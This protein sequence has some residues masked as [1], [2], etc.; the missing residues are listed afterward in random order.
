MGYTVSNSGCLKYIITATFFP[1]YIFF[2]FSCLRNKMPRIFARLIFGMFL[3]LIGVLSILI[4]DVTSHAQYEHKDNKSLCLFDIEVG[5]NYSVQPSTL[6]MHWA[7]LI[8]ANIFLG[9]G[10]YLVT[11]TTFE[12]ISAQSPNAMKG[13]IIGVF[14]T[15]RGFFSLICSLLLIPFSLKGI[16][17]SSHMKE[18]PPV[19]NCGFGYFSFICIVALIGLVLFSIVAKN[20][21]YRERDDRPYDQRF[22]VDFYSRAIE[23]RERYDKFTL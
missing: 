1:L 2:M 8:P 23:R 15:I 3:L 18:H 9:I 7:V 5:K 4:S 22:V 6:D 10:P 17:S 16:W 20:Y 14:Y 19:T 21:K 11:T 13:L 12:F